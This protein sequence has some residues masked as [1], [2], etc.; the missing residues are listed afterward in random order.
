[1]EKIVFGVQMSGEITFEDVVMVNDR[2]LLEYLPQGDAPVHMLLDVRQVTKYPMSIR[3]I[4]DTTAYLKHPSMGW[5]INVGADSPVM[6]SIASIVTQVAGIKLRTAA[7]IDE[8]HEVL[9]RVDL[10]LQNSEF[11]TG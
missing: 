4:T 7:S 10:R 2:A 5:M 6:R 8:A 3:A 11:P 1:V 9:R